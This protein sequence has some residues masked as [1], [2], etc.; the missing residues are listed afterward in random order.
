MTTNAANDIVRHFSTLRDPRINRRKLHKLTDIIG[1]SIIAVIGSAEG[2]EDIEEFAKAKE[3]WLRSF[4]ELENGIPSHDTIA[5]VFQRI[6]SVAFEN[7]FSR[8]VESLRGKRKGGEIVAIDGKTLRHSFDRAAEQSPLH[9][10]SAFATEQRLVLAQRRVGDKSNE[11][12]AI[13]ALLDMIN[14]SGTTITID[15]MGCQ[16][17]IAEKIRDKDADY[18]LALKGN[19]PNL[20]NDV[21]EFFQNEEYSPEKCSTTTTTDGGHGRI[22]ERK[23][24]ITSDLSPLCLKDEWKDL[25]SIGM[26]ESRR[27][28]KDKIESETRYYLTSHE[29]DAQLFASAVRGHWGIENKLHWIMDV[30]FR[31][32]ESRIRAGNGAHNFA[33]LRRIAFNLTKSYQPPKP[34]SLKR[35]RKLA[36]WSDNYILCILLAGIQQNQGI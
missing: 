11:I 16:K 1:L 36:Y 19:H 15:A 8:W 28:V 33:I 30:T 13:P 7:C 2:W 32:D 21:K 26:V 17:D 35:K 23:Y 3:E 10:V 18:V 31:E 4:L 9:L 22:E 27:E 6:D 20:Y 5:R 29:A 25:K 24:C 12:T 14:I 34:K